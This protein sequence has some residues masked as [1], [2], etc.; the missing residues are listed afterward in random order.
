[1]EYIGTGKRSLGD[2]GATLRAD[3]VRPEQATAERRRR[4]RIRTWRSLRPDQPVLTGRL[5]IEPGDRRHP[6][7]L[8]LAVWCPACKAMHWH[9]WV[10]TER[11]RSDE[12]AHRA[13]HCY[14][15]M[16]PPYRNGDYFIS[17]GGLLAEE[18]RATLRRCRELRADWERRQGSEVAR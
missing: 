15:G 8:D 3:I 2:H 4:P 7:A 11:F 12:I 16:E 14:R 1:M 13:V 9:G 10:S 17:P 6:P 5:S 18:N